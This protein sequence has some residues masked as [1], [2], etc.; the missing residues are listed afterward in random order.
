MKKHKKRKKEATS[1]KKKPT[2]QK[3]LSFQLNEFDAKTMRQLAALPITRRP[4]DNTELMRRSLH[5]YRLLVQSKEETLIRFL[6]EHLDS[7]KNDAA[8]NLALSK[9]ISS[10]VYAILIAKYGPENVVQYQNVDDTLAMLE[11]WQ[12]AGGKAPEQASLATIKSEPQTFDERIK[13][14]IDQTV[15]AL[16]SMLP[17]EKS[18]TGQDISQR[19][20]TWDILDYPIGHFPLEDKQ[21]YQGRVVNYKESHFGKCAME[22]RFN[23]VREAT[24]GEQ[25]PPP[26]PVVMVMANEIGSIAEGHKIIIES[27]RWE[28][29]KEIMV[30]KAFNLTLGGGTCVRNKRFPWET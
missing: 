28:P 12:S 11:H 7:S 3:S 4:K 15:I 29:G 8:A 9:D 21:T 19:M 18:L 5:V 13:N 27:K 1:R 22:W 6:K 2:K 20:C 23:L 14:V 26:I 10:A 25:I 24:E 30:N 16:D 17:K